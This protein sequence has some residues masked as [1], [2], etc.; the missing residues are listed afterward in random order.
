LNSRATV[1]TNTA[2]RQQI[3]FS[4]YWSNILCN[5]D[6]ALL[7]FAANGYQF[8]EGQ[9]K[10]GYASGGGKQKRHFCKTP[11]P[12][13]HQAFGKPMLA[14]VK[15]LMNTPKRLRFLN[16]FVDKLQH[17]TYTDESKQ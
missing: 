4:R 17:P 13:C 1:F 10:L 5:R 9:L 12:E 11:Q 15:W 8:P 7:I 6:F 16:N 14:A 2:T 3:I